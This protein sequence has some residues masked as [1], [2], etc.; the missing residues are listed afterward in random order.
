MKKFILFMAAIL[1]FLSCSAAKTPEVNYLKYALYN[2]MMMG[3][4]RIYEV[5]VNDIHDEVILTM[6][7]GLDTPVRIKAGWDVVKKI[8]AIVVEY[9]MAGFKGEY[10]PRLEVTDG[11][12]W[13]FNMEM[14][15]GSSTSARGYEQWPKNGQEAFA[16]IIDLIDEL[17]KGKTPGVT[18]S[19]ELG[20][21][22][23]F[24]YEYYKDKQSAVYTMNQS[25]YSTS[26]YY[27]A[28]GTSTGGFWSSIGSECMDGLREEFEHWPFKE[29]EPVRLSSENK[30]CNRMVSV[31]KYEFGE[32]QIVEYGVNEDLF[33]T[34]TAFFK[35]LVQRIGAEHLN[36]G[37]Y[38]WTSYGPDG[39]VRRSIRYDSEGRVCG[40]YDAD[41]PF[42]TF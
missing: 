31:L 20:K 8:D 40:G 30:E 5:Q 9:K 25:E 1:P 14:R 33:N 13:T 37:E 11:Y 19:R 15:D 35:N 41:Q 4:D 7:K 28:F 21:L 16:A 3:G 38:T 42:A 12:R 26:C 23:G 18:V 36:K 29:M 22:T 10:K 2:T 27:R 24:R 6:T 39:K 32:I 17:A 34:V